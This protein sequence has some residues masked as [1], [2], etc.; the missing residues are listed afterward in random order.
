MAVLEVES[1]PLQFNGCTAAVVGFRTDRVEVEV[2]AAIVKAV[3][4]SAE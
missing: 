3:L 4:W 2:E 1:S